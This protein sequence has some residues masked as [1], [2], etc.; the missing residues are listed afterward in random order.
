MISI[1]L[2]WKLTEYRSVV[3]SPDGKTIASA[4]ADVAI[5]RLGRQR[6]NEAV[7]PN[8]LM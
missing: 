2:I 3:F 8:K 4:R 6:P 7:T 1:F 5:K